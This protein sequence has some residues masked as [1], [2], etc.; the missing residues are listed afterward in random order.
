MQWLWGVLDGGHRHKDWQTAWQ[1]WQQECSCHPGRWKTKIRRALSKALQ[2]ERWHATVE[3][4][5]GLLTRQLKYCGAI[6]PQAPPSTSPPREVCALCN[7]VFKDFRAWSVHAFK[8]HGRTEEIRSLADGL[9]CQCCLKHFATNVRLCRHL[10]NSV[11]CRR[12]LLGKLH[13]VS[14]LPGIGSRK[15]PKEHLHCAPTLQAAGPR[16]LTAG[17]YIEDELDRPA[18]EVLDCLA[19]LDF[20]GLSRTFDPDVLWE[21]DRLSPVFVFLPGDSS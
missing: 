18:A 5:A 21:R 13:R 11:N 1:E 14:P 3:Q 16:P 12:S 17:G 8:R 7:A 2:R 19:H 9:Q 4:H 15:A 6:A 20:D 10:R